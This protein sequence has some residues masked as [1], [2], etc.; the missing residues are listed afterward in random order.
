[1]S[2]LLQPGQIFAE[3][4]RVDRFLAEGGYGAV[5][6][7]EQIA[8]ELAVALKVLW[9]Q[10]L[11]SADAVEK[12]KLEARVAGRINSE[13]IVR[14]IDAGF[15]APT[16]MPFL[17]MELLVG[18]DL[19]AK[20]EGSGP[21]APDL[22]AQLLRQVGSALDKAHG[23]RDKS[24]TRSPIVHRDLKP[25]NLFL[26]HREDGSPVVK[27]LDFGIAKV[28]GA[29]TSV[30]REVKG[31]PL[32]MAYEQAAGEAISPQTDIWALGLITFYLLTG[33]NYWRAAE[34][35]EGSVAQLFAEVL[36]KPIVPP[37]YRIAEHRA[38][39]RFPPGFDAW[40]LRCLDREPRLRFA[41]AGEAA[42]TF[43]AAYDFGSASWSRTGSEVT[44]L[45]PGPPA[46]A[47]L[48]HASGRLP[49]AET[50]ASTAPPATVAMGA[51]SL[52]GLQTTRPALDGTISRPA[53]ANSKAG[54][55]IVGALAAL[56]L[57]A[58]GAAL[59]VRGAAPSSAVG[60]SAAAP[61]VVAPRAAASTLALAVEPSASASASVA[62][63]PPPVAASASAQVPSVAEPPL[64]ARGPGRPAAK[65][66]APPP[67]PPPSPT[68][69]Q[70]PKSDL[71]GD[72]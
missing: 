9:P 6:A 40:F 25:E 38:P 18:A 45:Q 53:P 34:S 49:I 28:L 27:I 1:M 70:R 50:L 30:T 35:P 22:V 44:Q 48:G 60:S 24:Q 59:F 16:R 17:V 54:V 12:F 47:A 56:G 61:T 10:V 19:H 11:A 66:L 31:T 23:F 62:S 57:A 33:K 46:L 63:R 69:S 8:T 15:D 7:A 43:A 21:L 42:S 2:N 41:S 64:G 67:S 39:N 65:P 3:R 68:P 36:N 58:G 51:R 72:R 14:V 37:S 32:F 52:G 5:Y 20:V 26:V 13:H 4:Y 29:R 71:Y 55:V